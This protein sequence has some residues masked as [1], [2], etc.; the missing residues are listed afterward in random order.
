MRDGAEE[1][2]Y[3]EGLRGFLQGNYPYAEECFNHLLKMNPQHDAAL[4]YLANLKFGNGQKEEAFYY[5]KAAVSADTSN[6][7]YPLQIAQFYLVDQQPEMAI[8]IYEDLLVR[9]PHKNELYYDLANL[10]LNQKELD[11][12]LSLIDEIEKFRGIS[13][14]TGFYRFNIL[15]IQGKREEAQPLLEELAQTAPSPRILTVLGDLYAEADKD[16]LAMECYQE[17]ITED[18]SYIPAIFGQA[19][20]HRMRQQYNAYFEKMFIFMDD[21]HLEVSMKIDYMDQLLQNR[22]FVSAYLKQ[23]DT[24]FTKLYKRH[25]ADTNVVYRYAG[26]LLQAGH[27]KRSVEVLQE[28]V[29]Y[30]P[31]EKGVWF[32]YLSIY[33]FLQQ[34]ENLYIASLEALHIFP[35]ESDFMTMSGIA[36]WQTN[37]IPLAISIFESILSLAKDRSA[38][39][40]QTLSILGDLYHAAGHH[41]KSFQS[42]EKSLKINPDQPGT[43]NNYAYFLSLSGKNLHKAYEMSKKSIDAE[44]KNATYLDTFGWVLYNLGRHQEAKSIFRQVLMYGTDLSAE[45]LDHYAEVLFALKDF[46]MAFMYWEQAKL[47]EKNPELEKKIEKRKSERQR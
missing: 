25:P 14:A 23:V 24:L 9:Y 21:A 4:F 6:Y 10:Y 13:E 16:T 39:L 19:E 26:F 5:M 30:F 42:Y 40:A 29:D 2:Y 47:K 46:D 36:A 8:K 28:I 35:K 18:P 15:M 31:K 3:L 43:L 33:H 45:V 34:W 11:K 12:A 27:E 41:N 32:Q 20:V 37:R 38:L 17:A 1:F 22:P 44:P 7:W